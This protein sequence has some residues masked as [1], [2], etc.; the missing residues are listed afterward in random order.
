M[1]PKAPT[2]LLKPFSIALRVAVGLLV[3]FAGFGIA[4]QLIA[5]KPALPPKDNPTTAMTVGT[6]LATR[7]DVPRAWSGYGSARTMNAVDLTA[8]VTGRVT[9]RPAA[10]EPGLPIGAGGLI[11]QLEQTDYLARSRAA[12]QFVAQALAELDSLDIDETAWTEQVRLAEEQ[13]SIE[14][15]ELS[16]ALDAL[17]RGA[18]SPSEIDRRTKALRV[19]ETQASTMRQQLERVPSRRDALQ[20]NLNRLRADADLARENLARTTVTSP[21]TGVIQRV[22]VEQDELLAVGAPVAR[23]VDLSRLEIPLKIPA[24]ALGYVRLGD[25]AALRPDGPGSNAWHG[26][27]VRIAP[28][29]DPATRTLTVF[30][31][32]TQDPGAF[33]SPDH[34]GATLLLP[35][36]F[37]VGVIS[38]SP[39]RGRLIVPRRAVQDGMVFL[40]TPNDRGGWTARRTPVETLFHTSGEFPAIDRYERQWS[41]VENEAIY[42]GTPIIVTN[43]DVMIDGLFVEIPSGGAG[44]AGAG[45]RP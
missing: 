45:E 4:R 24:T 20:A 12:D 32:V 10:I 40:A 13:A 6:I 41:V 18:S 42:G 30:V 36:Q 26:K 15:R 39:E 31:E 11:V 34:A 37:V 33:S 23:V 28:E 38:G 2:A 19:L 7:G 14:R 5:T 9:E 3:L 22:D 35:G 43:L 17:E 16:Q 1:P 8:Q 21:I 27:V 29:A 44:E 25:P